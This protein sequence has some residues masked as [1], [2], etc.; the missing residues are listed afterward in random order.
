MGRRLEH[1]TAADQSEIAADRIGGSPVALLTSVLAV[2]V[3]IVAIC[4]L[5]RI[6]DKSTVSIS[7]RAQL[8]LRRWTAF[9]SRTPP[10]TLP[11][12]SE[13]DAATAAECQQQAEKYARAD[14]GWRR[15]RRR[16]P[17]ALTATPAPPY[18]SI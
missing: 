6:N 15:L 10:E 12:Y 11:E 1:S 4:I 3:L 18:G 9:L 14:R 17:A 2:D 5:W 7:Q 8:C 16:D 13:A